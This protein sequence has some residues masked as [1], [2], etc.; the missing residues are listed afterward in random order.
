MKQHSSRVSFIAFGLLIVAI[1]VSAASPLLRVARASGTDILVGSVGSQTPVMDI[2]ST[3]QYVG[4]AFRIF[5]SADFSGSLTRVILSEKGTVAAS[6]SLANVHI[7]YDV[8]TT[9]PY[10]CASETFSESDPTFGYPTTFDYTGKATFTGLIDVGPTKT[11]CLYVVLDIRNTASNGETLEIEITSPATDVIV[12]GGP[13]IGAEIH[14]YPTQHNYPVP[15]IGTTT[16]RL[17]PPSVVTV[18][19]TGTQA[20]SL[21]IPST[22]QYLG[23]AFRML[24]DSGSATITSVKISEKGTVNAASALTSVRLRYD[25]DTSSPYDC[26]SE[27]Y[28]ESDPLYG[29]TTNFNA[30]SQAT[31][32]GAVTVMPTQAACFY[33]IFDVAT[34]AT[35]GQTVEIEITNPSTDVVLAQGGSITQTTSVAIPGTTTLA[36]PPASGVSIVGIGA[37]APTLAIPSTAQYVGG[38]FRFTSNTTTTMVTKVVITASGTAISGTSGASIA[39]SLGTVRLYY[40][41]DQSAPY[42]CASEFFSTSDRMFGMPTSFDSTSKQAVFTAAVGAEVAVDPTH[43]ACFYVVLDVK[44]TAKNG[45][46]L[47][48]SIAKPSTDVVV[49]GG[50]SIITT[51]AVSIDG[52]T[53]LSSTPPPAGTINDGDLVRCPTCLDGYKVY[54]VKAVGTKKFIRHILDTTVIGFYGHLAAGFPGNIKDV[55]SLEGL[56]LSAWVRL[57]MT[58]DPL[59]WRIYEVNGDRTKHWITCANPDYCGETWVRHGGDPDGVYTISAQEMQYYI[60]GP[61]VFLQ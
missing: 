25:L 42:D 10:D 21:T 61:N 24:P 49:S 12:S 23:G 8:D 45:T 6:T 26:A 38:G 29:Q 40:D 46:T 7:H 60:T 32:S 37:Q 11:A 58:S 9:S 16:L 50:I 5:P 44:D 56:L 30:S 48:I 35:S 59:T 41:I 54:V 55:P 19:A 36:T 57:P 20:T 15:L 31:F 39:T 14:P 52:T 28:A 3:A 34:S 2:P 53:T 18:A 33:V 4:G 13:T 51:A 43:A 17:P 1:L 27:S 47:E 22:A